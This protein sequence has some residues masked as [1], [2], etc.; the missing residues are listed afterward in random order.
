MITENEM[1]V[2]KDAN[3]SANSED[4]LHVPNSSKSGCDEIHDP[5]FE[6][7]RSKKRKTKTVVD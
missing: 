1:W 7:T 3:I 5:N 4:A 2:S 6:G